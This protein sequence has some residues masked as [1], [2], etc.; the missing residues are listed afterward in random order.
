MSQAN[1]EVELQW[2]RPARKPVLKKKLGRLL[3][4]A[5]GSG[6]R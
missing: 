1:T 6:A 5:T 2:P 3:I 4:E